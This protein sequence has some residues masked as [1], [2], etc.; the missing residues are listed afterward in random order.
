MT[1]LQNKI[2]LITGVGK[3]IGKAIMDN[4]LKEGAYVYAI[5]RSKI[6]KKSLKDLSN[7]KSR[8]QIFY[9]DVNNTKI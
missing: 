6:D 7:L 9:S 5:T 3:G 8:F 4:C 2:I 1:N